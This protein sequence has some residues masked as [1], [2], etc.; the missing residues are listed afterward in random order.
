MLF[1]VVG[2]FNKVGDNDPK[3]IQNYIEVFID[4]I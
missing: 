2:M 3:L 4:A 1:T